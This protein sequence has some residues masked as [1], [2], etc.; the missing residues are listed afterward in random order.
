M[1]NLWAKIKLWTKGIVFGVLFLYA[2]FFIVKNLGYRTKVWLIFFGEEADHSTLVVVLFSFLAGVVATILFR[3]IHLTLK[4]LREA[5]ERAIK[6]KLE[7]EHQEKEAAL[8]EN[9]ERENRERERILR[10]KYDREHQARSAPS[11]SA[12]V[13]SAPIVAA[14]V[15][16]TSSA[17]APASRPDNKTTPT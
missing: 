17:P 4:Q 1:G 9:F 7:R 6:D 5:R 13:V 15:A 3:A 14:P 8:K 12:P 11:V 10:E 16:S 2:A